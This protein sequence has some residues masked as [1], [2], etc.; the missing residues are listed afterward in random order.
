MAV[1]PRYPRDLE[2]WTEVSV[3]HIKASI[4]NA[5]ATGPFGSSIGS[6]FFEHNGVPVIRGRQSCE[7][8]AHILVDDDLVF[9]SEAKATE[10]QRSAVFKG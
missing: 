8:R 2:A 10:F 5:L 9:V 7:R 4:E 1:V 3:D 6:R